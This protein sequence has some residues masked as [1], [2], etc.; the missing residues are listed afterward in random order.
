MRKKVLIFINLT[1]FLILL[2][3]SGN[4]YADSDETLKNTTRVYFSSEITKTY[5]NGDCILLENYD[6]EGNK[7]Y[8]LIDA[9]RYI[10]KKDSEGNNSTVV[11]EFLKGHGVEK[12][13]FFAITHSHGDHNGD[14]LTVLDNF[15]IDTI[16]MK[17]FDEK[18]SPSGEQARYEDI[19]ERAVAKNIKVVGVSYLSLKSSEISPSRSEDF[20]N[21]TIDAKDELFESF[22]YNS[23]QDNNIIFRFGSST[24]RI[25]NWEMFNEEGNQY[26]TGVT[27][28]TTREIDSDENNNSIAFLLTQGN[29]KAFFSGDMNNS[30]E[31]KANGRIGDEDRL[32][33]AIGKVDLLKL[34]HHGYQYSNT[35]NYIN[36][37]KPQYATI[38][39]DVGRAYKDIVNWMSENN[40]KYLYT[41]EDEY[42]VAATITNNDIYM[43]FGTTGVVKKINGQLYYV[44]ENSKYKDY[45]K[46]LYK[47]EYQDKEVQVSSWNELKEIIDNNKKEI[48]SINDESKTCTLYRVIINLNEGGDWNAD[49]TIEIENQQNIVLNTTE[50]ITMLRATSLKSTPLFLIK[51]CLDVGTENMVGK[52][53]IDGNKNNI[54]SS[55]TLIKIES[56]TLNLY[57]N[58]VLCN[59]MNKVTSRTRNST[60]QAYTAFGSAIYS[61]DGGTI[62]MYGGEIVGNSQDVVLTFTLPKEIN[63]HYSYSTEGTGIYMINNSVF[64]MYGGKI[65]NNESQNHSI[66]KTDTSYT[67]SRLN[68]IIEQKCNGVGIYAQFNSEVNL[69]GGEISGNTAKNCATALV[70]KATDTTKNTNVYS[71]NGGI[72][73]VGIFLAGSVLRI[74]NDFVISNN[75]AELN[76]K[77]TIDESTSVRGLVDSGVRGLSV[78]SYNSIVDI[79]GATIKN[80]NYENNTEVIKN[81]TIGSAGTSSASTSNLGGGL[82]ITSNSIFHIKNLEVNNCNSQYGG[83]IYISAAS[84]KISNSIIANNTAVGSGGGIFMDKN[85]DLELENTKIR[86]NK[87]VTG[88]GGGI[89]AYGNLNIFG[90]ETLISNNTASTYGGGIM[91]KEKTILNDGEISNNTSTKYAGG[92]VRVDGTLVMNGGIIKNNN[93]NTNG[94]GVDYNSTNAVFYKTGGIIENNV[95]GAQGNEIYPEDKISI[96]IV[97]PTLDTEEIS[98]DWTNKDIVITIITRDDETGIKTVAVNDEIIAR[99]S[100]T[101]EYTLSENGT[102]KVIVT[103]NA[104]NVEKKEFTISNID[105]TSPVITG[106]VDEATYNSEIEINATDGLSGIKNVTLKKDGKVVNYNLGDKLTESGNYTILVEDN[107]SNESEIS[108]IIDRS[109]K[110]DEIVIDGLSDEWSNENQKIKLTINNQVKDVKVNGEKIELQDKS[111]IIAVE[112][113]SSYIIDITDLDGNIITKAIQISNIDKNKPVVLGVTEGTTYNEKVILTLRDEESGISKKIITRNEEELDI[114][115][116]TEEVH[117]NIEI[118]ENGKYKITVIDNAGNETTINFN[119]EIKPFVIDEGEIEPEKVPEEIEITSEDDGGKTETKETEI[120]SEDDGGK[121]DN[122]RTLKILPYTGN[123]G[124]KILFIIIVITVSA[125][126]WKIKLKGYKDIK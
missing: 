22:Y 80:S 89:Y 69:L 82:D 57:N 59:N 40:V 74:S 86:G 15:E 45:T 113:N 27:T 106:V 10:S 34:G 118:T 46:Y 124:R 70:S 36:V 105:K 6:S 60:T 61:L 107:V 66:V 26:I 62:N 94:G 115:K 111:Y 33:D 81:G 5:E 7:I 29:K 49:S 96:D 35:E 75:E 93:A 126:I 102:Y 117:N 31:D 8:G 109:L 64:N 122:T 123:E 56:G 32:K 112:E 37:L 104:G 11:K 76:S 83:G 14:A 108:F 4:V 92:G 48:V 71:I 120:I 77:I 23:D 55:S 98:G 85:V 50:N 99:K 28:N 2:L 73:G 95:A 121:N 19:I 78:Y 79:D 110:N 47:I 1:F 119:I 63:H 3:I 18:W 52:I 43:G 90:S 42:E 67:N 125:L 116:I 21:N 41:T 87:T 53:T 68:K 97:K 24:I 103:D 91:V 114:E 101:Y 12:L 72:Y 51:G 13:E 9:G 30:D 84:G 16:Y 38:T 44:P 65:S 25:F 58:A 20:I 39:N 88:S 100:G 17:E 54:D